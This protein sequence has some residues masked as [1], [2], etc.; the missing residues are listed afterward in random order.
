MSTNQFLTAIN[1]ISLKDT[2]LMVYE[3]EYDDDDDDVTGIQAT[4]AC[5]NYEAVWDRTG[6]LLL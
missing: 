1:N 5:P 4:E 2:Y 3:Y 6:T